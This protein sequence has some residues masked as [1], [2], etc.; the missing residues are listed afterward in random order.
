[1]RRAAPDPADEPGPGHVSARGGRHGT[2]WSRGATGTD[3]PPEPVIDARAHGAP[4]TAPF[5]PAQRRREDTWP[6]PSADP[7][8]A[9]PNG[10]T[11]TGRPAGGRPTP[12]MGVPQAE[13]PAPRTGTGP[14]P[15]VPPAAEDV[16]PPADVAAPTGVVPM[17]PPGDPTATLAGP[18][19]LPEDA[20]SGEADEDEI[21]DDLPDDLPDDDGSTAEGW[22]LVRAAQ[23]GDTD[24][25]GQLFDRYHDT[26]FRFVLFR[27]GDRPAAEDLTQETFVRAYRR[28]TSVSYQGRDIGAWFVTIARNLVLDHVKSSRYRLESSTAE[29]AD[30][31]PSSFRPGPES[32][33]IAGA[34]HAELL[35]CVARLGDDQQECIALRFLQGLSVAETA[36]IMGRNEGAVKALQHRAVRRLAQLLPE[37]LR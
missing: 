11:R 32:E 1:M 20:A 7:P 8:S 29:V 33:V 9:S 4:P 10:H 15:P 25:F 5:Y 12:P 31:A 23:D 30:V 24:A 18:Q 26:V 22:A 14:L 27:L 2:G 6:P 37:G 3:T 17:Q 34:T 21:A 13:P 36:E 19:P 35:R 28:I 16:P